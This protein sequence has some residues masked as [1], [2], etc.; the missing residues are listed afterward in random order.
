MADKLYIV[1]RSDLSLGAQACQA[2]HAAVLFSHL[3]PDVEGVWWEGSKNV[4]LLAVPDEAALL[5]LLRRASEAGIP[6]AANTEPDLGDSLTSL[7]IAPS[8]KRL[9]RHLPL[10]LVDREPTLA[11]AV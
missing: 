8:G 3:R 10:L 1:V 2:V 7:A 9:V 11:W 5:V 6:Y 4:A